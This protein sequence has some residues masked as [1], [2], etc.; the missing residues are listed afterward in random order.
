[1]FLTHHFLRT[2][3]ATV[4]LF[5]SSGY[6]VTTEPALPAEIISAAGGIQKEKSRLK[7]LELLTD[8]IKDVKKR[9]KHLPESIDEAEIPRV[10]MLYELDILF[11]TMSP[12]RINPATCPELQRSVRNWAN[13]SGATDDEISNTG[14]LVIEVIKSVCMP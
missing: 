7:R 12:E 6:A 2:F 13:P 14:R 5:S 9:V 8:L 10:Q 3:L 1:M 11:G 4:F